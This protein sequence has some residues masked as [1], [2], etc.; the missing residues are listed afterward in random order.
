MESVRLMSVLAK[1][2]IDVNKMEKR[3]SLV[4]P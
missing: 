2:D 3:F 4:C 1:A